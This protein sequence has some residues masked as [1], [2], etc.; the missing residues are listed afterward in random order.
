MAI[1]SIVII[2][3]Q[4]VWVS[5]SLA[6]PLEPLAHH[7]NIVSFS[8]FYRYSLVDPHLYRMNWFYFLLFVTGPFVVLIG[9]MI[10]LWPFLY[11]IRIQHL[12]L[13]SFD[14]SFVWS[15]T[16]NQKL[17]TPLFEKLIIP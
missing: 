3:H 8:L 17:V 6:A 2:S 14:S 7:R 15:F 5:P 10:F 11:V 1:S 16:K 13:E 9:C 12:F 4:I